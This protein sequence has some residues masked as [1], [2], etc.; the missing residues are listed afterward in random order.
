MHGYMHTMA[1][2]GEREM[3]S[4][5]TVSET[6][7]SNPKQVSRPGWD[8]NLR[9]ITVRTNVLAPCCRRQQDESTLT[10]QSFL[11]YVERERADEKD[12]SSSMPNYLIPLEGVLEREDSYIRRLH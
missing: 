10:V 11:S 7:E 8:S 12:V 3:I 4:N 1:D 6:G 5:S 2:T 9:S